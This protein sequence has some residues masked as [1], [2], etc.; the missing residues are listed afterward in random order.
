M[1]VRFAC[2]ALCRDEADALSRMLCRVQGETECTPC[3]EGTATNEEESHFW[4]VMILVGMAVSLWPACFA[5]L[6]NDFR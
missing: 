1:F 5:R 6:C 3:A 4:F 2:N